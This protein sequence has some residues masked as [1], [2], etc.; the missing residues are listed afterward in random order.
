M[1]PGRVHVVGIGVVVAF[2]LTAVG[3]TVRAPREQATGSA[4]A[5]QNFDEQIQANARRMLEEGKRVFRFD[6]FGSEDFWGGKLRLHES[7]AG[8]K[9][10]GVGPA[11]VRK[12]PCRWA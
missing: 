4:A 10:G 1:L 7:L 9:L 8:Q 3:L 11:S 12:R 6:T 2:W 5:P